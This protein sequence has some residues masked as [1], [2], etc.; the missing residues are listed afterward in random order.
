[1]EGALTSTTQAFAWHHTGFSVVDLNK[2]LRFYS[3]AFG[4]EPVFEAMDMSDLIQ[5]LTGVPGLRADLVQCKSKM[6]N[7]VLELIK[8]RNIPSTASELL[9]IQPGQTHNCFLV[10]NL[11]AAI[12]EV[13]KAG[14]QL[15]GSVTEFSEGKAAYLSDGSGNAIELE[16]AKPGERH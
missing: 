3:Q 14:G 15:L 11:D 6:S 8:F 12:E 13:K 10:E 7:Q 4:F 2:S 1:L 16:Q 9:P 5:H